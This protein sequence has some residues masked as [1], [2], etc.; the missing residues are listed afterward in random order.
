MAKTAKPVSTPASSADQVGNTR[1]ESGPQGTG[2][3]EGS[4]YHDWLVDAQ[5]AAQ[6]AN[7]AANRLEAWCNLPPD[8][9]EPTDGRKN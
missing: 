1:G 4:A 2:G 8:G 6:Q 5:A 3:N 7:E 9:N